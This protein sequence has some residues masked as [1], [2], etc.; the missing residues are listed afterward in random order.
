MARLVLLS[1][2]LTGRTFELKGA[3]TT[4]GRVPDN[5]FQIPEASVSSHHCELHLQGKDVLVKDLDSTNGTFINGERVTETLLKAG[6]ILRLGMIEMRLES[7]DPPPNVA[8]GPAAKKVLDKTL[9]IPQGV[10]LDDL[11]GNR[12]PLD[13]QK[14]GIEKKNLTGTKIFVGMAV[15]IG[16]IL[17]VLLLY[18]VT[19]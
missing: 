10:K 8:T 13:F 14:G 18:V 12:T 2:G 5:D 3:K 4:V 17:V 11:E 15:A 1:E 7:G 19:K 16:L 6:Q 9:V